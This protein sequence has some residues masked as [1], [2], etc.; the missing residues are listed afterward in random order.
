[1]RKDRKSRR[2]VGIFK[3]AASDILGGI[4]ST[5]TARLMGKFLYDKPRFIKIL[6][7]PP[8]KDMVLPVF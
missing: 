1:M 7:T 6:G 2:T 5:F 3:V 4:A 8:S